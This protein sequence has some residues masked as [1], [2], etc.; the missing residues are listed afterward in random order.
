MCAKYREANRDICVQR[1]KDSQAKNRAHYSA[2][3]IKWQKDNRERN[4]ENRRKLYAK[5]SAKDIARSRRRQ[6]R[7][8]HGEMIMSQAEAAEVQGLYDF[9][10]IFSGFEVDHI[11]PLNGEFVSGLHVLKN[12]QVLSVSENRSKSN[13]FDTAHKE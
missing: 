10:R 12:L 9:C 3:S 2:V 4:L 5:N 13:K 11:I 6:G 8:R 7:I 1:S